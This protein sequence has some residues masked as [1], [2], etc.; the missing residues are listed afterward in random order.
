MKAEQVAKMLEQMTTNEP[1]T[2]VG[3]DPK[4]DLKEAN[5]P[6]STTQIGASSVEAISQG[7]AQLPLP[8]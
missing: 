5:L 3:G 7:I 4:D 1:S 2:A 6:L 8:T